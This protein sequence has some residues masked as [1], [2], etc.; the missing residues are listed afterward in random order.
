MTKRDVLFIAVKL[1]GLVSLAYAAVAI[2]QAISVVVFTRD[3]YGYASWLLL[4][5][6]GLFLIPGV[7]FLA[8]AGPI[9]LRLAGEDARLPAELLGGNQ[10]AVLAVTLRVVG[11]I[12]LAYAIPS[13]VDYSIRALAKGLHYVFWIRV[14]RESL[15]AAVGVYFLFGAPGLLN[16]ICRPS[17]TRSDP[18]VPDEAQR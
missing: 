14:V 16:I 2:V 12:L 10:R 17:G 8:C 11:A 1:L 3:L 15:S 18:Q 13:L 6:G 4:G 7:V 9:S 5:E